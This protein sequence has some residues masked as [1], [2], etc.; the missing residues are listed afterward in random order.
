LLEECSAAP[1]K[2]DGVPMSLRSLVVVFAAYF[3]IALSLTNAKIDKTLIHEA[4]V[5]LVASTK[6]SD[7]GGKRK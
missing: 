1:R 5:L 2:Y 4:A 3:L 6:I 7:S